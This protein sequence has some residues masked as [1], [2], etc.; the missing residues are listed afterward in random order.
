MAYLSLSFGSWK[1]QQNG[2]SF[3]EGLPS[4]TSS[5]QIAQ[6]QEYVLG[7]DHM[8]RQDARISSSLSIRTLSAMN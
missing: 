5:Q 6:G 3:V 1:S 2:S 7:T 4:H 8:V